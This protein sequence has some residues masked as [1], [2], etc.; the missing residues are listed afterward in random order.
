MV[1]AYVHTMQENQ[2]GESYCRIESWSGF[3]ISTFR[4]MD[5]KSILSK[6]DYQN[7]F[8]PSKT[9]FTSVQ[10]SSKAMMRGFRKAIISGHCCWL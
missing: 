5:F 8:K 2:Q 7:Y 1:F 4:A 9:G 10:N 3:V 6:A